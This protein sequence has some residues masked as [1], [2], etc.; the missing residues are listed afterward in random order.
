MYVCMY[1]RD[2]VRQRESCILID[3]SFVRRRKTQGTLQYTPFVS[4][5][6]S[7]PR[8]V[9]VYVSTVTIVSLI[10]P[11]KASQPASQRYTHI[12]GLG[13][14]L[15]WLRYVRYALSS[16]VSIFSPCWW[17]IPYTLISFLHPPYTIPIPSRYPYCL[18]PYH[19]YALPFFASAS[20][21]QRCS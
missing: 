1:G 12:Q 21:V 4:R 19:G 5:G 16:R 3:Q 14:S 11:E 17:P 15:S 13:K 7:E 18:P 2:S 20:L 10:F 9:L 6:W 8:S